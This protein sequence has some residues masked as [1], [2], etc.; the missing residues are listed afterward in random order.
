MPSTSGHRASAVWLL[1]SAQSL[2]GIGGVD[3]L[4]TSAELGRLSAWK[5]MA[6]EVELPVQGLDLVIHLGN[7]VIDLRAPPPWPT[8]GVAFLLSL[9]PELQ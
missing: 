2:I 7:E 8:D 4:S 5:V 9:F 6:D 1:S 3:A